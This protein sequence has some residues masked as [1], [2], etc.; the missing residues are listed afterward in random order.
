MKKK[1]FKV[2][3]APGYPV[4][5]KAEQSR[6]LWSFVNENGSPLPDPRNTLDFDRLNK[7]LLTC[8]N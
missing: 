4:E 2:Y 1:F 5:P 7:W 8:L 6:A 3:K